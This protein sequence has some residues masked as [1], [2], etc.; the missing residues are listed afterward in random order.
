[1]G[2]PL[3]SAHEL[4]TLIDAMRDAVRDGQPAALAT[5]TATRGATFR[6]AGTRMLVRAD[7]SAVCE[8]SGGCPQHDIVQRAR[9]VIAGDRPEL[10]RYNA[11]SGLDVL[12]E[13]GCGG[14]LDV[15]IEPLVDARAGAFFDALADCLE[16]RRD[17]V[18][19][20]VF[21]LDGGIVPPR[22]ALWCGDRS[23]FDDLGDAGLRQA[24]VH[25]I[26]SDRTP[27]AA[28]LRLPATNGTADVLIERIGPQHALVAIGSN[29]TARA[30]LSTGHA[31]GWCTTLVDS[32]PERLQE[33]MLPPGAHAVHATPQTLCDVLTFDR[34]SSVVVMTHNLAQD[35][36]WLAVLRDAPVAYLGAIGSRE[37]T[38]RMLQ[39]LLPPI[40]GLHAP[41]GLD[42]GS[43]TPREIALA[44][45]AEI[46]AALNGRGGGSLRDGNGALHA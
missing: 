36:A 44:I 7:G 24:V 23:C 13:M 31:L 33:A 20:T 37:R 5:I 18:V 17:V 9:R 22:R 10:A 42:I 41:A 14:E 8:L 32:N 6:R 29:A 45:A 40:A 35:L 3:G 2:L 46:I 1:M 26:A 4:W 21:A 30:L 25:A 39:G 11:D 28:T 15:L 27:R 16:S 12:V 38:S 19:A 43:E 34:Y